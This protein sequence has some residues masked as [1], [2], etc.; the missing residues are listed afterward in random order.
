MRDGCDT[1]DGL[2]SRTFSITCAN[3][4][5]D[6]NADTTNSCADSQHRRRQR[7]RH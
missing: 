7:T 5:T 3:A 4:D 6:A 1:A 2:D